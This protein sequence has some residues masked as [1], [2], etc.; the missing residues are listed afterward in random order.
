MLLLDHKILTFMIISACFLFPIDSLEPAPDALL[1]TQ[2][3][4]DNWNNPRSFEAEEYNKSWRCGEISNDY[5]MKNPDWRVVE[6]LL[7]GNEKSHAV[8]YKI[9]DEKLF[10]R[11]SY[12]LVEYEM[13]DWRNQT[14]QLYEYD[15]HIPTGLHYVYLNAD[16]FELN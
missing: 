5:I 2:F 15:I 16:V 6:I 4:M 8:N 10:I 11:D 14:L 13:L 12:W 1:M 9:I 3:V 7:E